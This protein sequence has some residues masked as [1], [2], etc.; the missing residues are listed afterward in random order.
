MKLRYK[1]LS[2]TTVMAG[3]FNPIV[4]Q[5]LVVV[6]SKFSY[7]YGAVF[8]VIA[9]ANALLVAGQVWAEYSAGERVSFERKIKN[10]KN[11]KKPNNR[12]KLGKAGR[13]ID[14]RD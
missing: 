13:F 12:E 1:I 5:E 10:M 11:S 8:V 4:F 6:G 9:L 2:V 14:E 7:A 3:V